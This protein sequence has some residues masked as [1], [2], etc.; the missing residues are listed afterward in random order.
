MSPDPIVT[1]GRE[2]VGVEGVIWVR[3]HG[4]AGP[5]V[6]DDV[7]QHAPGDDAFTSTLSMPPCHR[8]WLVDEVGREPV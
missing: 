3:A 2:I 6:P 7:E 4:R 8:A 1:L 5:P